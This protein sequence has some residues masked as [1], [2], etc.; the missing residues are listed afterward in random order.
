MHE[1]VFM[2]LCEMATFVSD[3]VSAEDDKEAK[4]DEDDDS[5]HPSDHSVVHP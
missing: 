1:C 4:H 3:E 5:Y 2:R